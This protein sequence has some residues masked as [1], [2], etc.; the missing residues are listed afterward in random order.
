MKPISF[1]YYHNS[2]TYYLN[3]TVLQPLVEENTI[4]LPKGSI[5]QLI[6]DS[7]VLGR[8]DLPNSSKINCFVEPLAQE[9]YSCGR[10]VLRFTATQINEDN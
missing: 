7:P 5:I 9:V 4:V 2:K 6:F 8:T 1:K 10:R 3:G